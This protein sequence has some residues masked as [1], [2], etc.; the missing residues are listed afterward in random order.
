MKT[1]WEKHK[2]YLWKFLFANLVFVLATVFYGFLLTWLSTVI[3]GKTSSLQVYIKPL[4]RSVVIS[5]TGTMLLQY[6]LKILEKNNKSIVNIIPVF[7][8][9]VLQM[10][11]LIMVQ[12]P[13]IV[14]QKVFYSAGSIV[15]SILLILFALF[16]IWAQI[17]LS[18]GMLAIADRE[19]TAWDAMMESWSLT[20]GRFFFIFK[21]YLL[22]GLVLLGG[23]FLLG[24]GFLF[25]LSPVITGYV[26]LYRELQSK[27]N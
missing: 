15:V 11:M 13:V 2:P 10:I 20:S 26:L 3:L 25:A 14:I 7:H 6:Y 18:F 24:I 4:I 17:R 19:L 22:F 1:I 8:A 27:S 16:I 9:F 12:L 23:M 21:K 5:L